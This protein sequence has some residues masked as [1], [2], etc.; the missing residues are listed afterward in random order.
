LSARQDKPTDKLG[1][2]ILLSLSI[3]NVTNNLLYLVESYPEKD[4]KISILDVN[5]KTPSLTEWGEH[6]V[7]IAGDDYRRVVK[8]VAPGQTIHNKID[9]S[10]IY[11]LIPGD[12]YTITVKRQVFKMGRKDQFTDVLSNTVSVRVSKR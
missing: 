8:K 9:I 4:Y 5:G 12:T 1:A 7:R 10:K 6:L 3:H 2:P 11:H